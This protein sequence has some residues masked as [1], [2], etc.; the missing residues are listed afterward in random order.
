MPFEWQVLIIHECP[1]KPGCHIRI[2]PTC[3][4][5][6][7]LGYKWDSMYQDVRRFANK[8]HVC[9]ISSSKIRIDTINIILKAV[10]L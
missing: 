9:R 5:I 7:K 10:N 2:Q 4:M 8:C 3:N 1:T 6:I